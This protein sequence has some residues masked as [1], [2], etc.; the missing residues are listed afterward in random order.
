MHLIDLKAAAKYLGLS[1][2]TVRD[3]ASAGT[4]PCYRIGPN[5]GRLKFRESELD[6]YVNGC[7]VQTAQS[8][9]RQTRRYSLMRPDGKP[10][11]HIG[12]KARARS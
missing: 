12:S 7:R 9:T 8:T 3:M 1:E 10:L 4:I 5:G 2:R 11:Q 6:A